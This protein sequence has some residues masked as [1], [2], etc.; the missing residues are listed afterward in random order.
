MFRYLSLMLALVISA[1]VQAGI[2]TNG[3]DYSWQQDSVWFLG[4]EP[5]EYCVEINGEYHLTK[6]Q[7]AKEVRRAL[8]LWIEFFKRRGLSNLTF[9]NLARLPHSPLSLTFNE[10]PACTEGQAQ[11]RFVFGARTPEVERIRETNPTFVAIAYRKNYDHH[12]LRNAGT[13]FFDR[14]IRDE[15]KL[16]HILVHEI[17]HI[18]GF[19]HDSLPIMKNHV[20]EFVDNPL[21]QNL[22]GQ[23]EA[24]TWKYRL[25]DGDVLDF[26]FDGE[27]DGQAVTNRLLPQTNELFG[28]DPAGFHQLKLRV[29]AN[30][31]EGPVHLVLTATE[32]PT[33][34]TVSMRGEFTPRGSYEERKHG[35]AGP[36]LSSFFH[37]QECE[38]I[39]SGQRRLDTRVLRTELEGAFEL[40]GNFYPA[41]LESKP[42]SVLNVF[43]PGAHRWWS[44]SDYPAVRIWTKR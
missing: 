20:G 38:R 1:Q 4:E 19:P 34:K 6:Q 2:F 13:I 39:I 40:D 17:G 7:A 21:A 3:G 5:V 31:D 12:T 27:K 26:T 35:Q 28:F 10:V 32:Y 30:D 22:L 9:M 41:T 15:A 25:N 24:P 44:V 33:G 42:G 36:V 43:L 23:I 14:W 37:S 29:E 11:I 18:F 16:F 8:D